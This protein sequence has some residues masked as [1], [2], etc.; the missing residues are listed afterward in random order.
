MSIF[1]TINH[2]TWNSVFSRAIYCMNEWINKYHFHVIFTISICILFYK[3]KNTMTFFIFLTNIRIYIFTYQ[4]KE[5]NSTHTLKGLPTW[6]SGKEST[7]QHRRHR[8]TCWGGKSPW[9]RAWQ[10]TPASLPGKSRGQ[11][12]LAGCSPWGRKQMYTTD[13][14]THVYSLLPPSL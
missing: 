14:Y 3:Y 7:C 9:R 5:L 6:N 11:R 10:P 2:S 12:S 13:M 1:L 8:F 4:H